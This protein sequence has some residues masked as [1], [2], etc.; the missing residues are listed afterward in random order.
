MTIRNSILRARTSRPRAPRRFVTRTL[1]GLALTALVIVVGNNWQV[2]AQTN[3]FVVEFGGD[4]TG[5]NDCTSPDQPCATI[6][7]AISQSGSGDLIVLGPGTYFE[8][9]TVSTGVIIQGDGTVGSTVNGNDAGSVFIVNNG[10]TASL[11]N[12][13]ITKDRKSTRLNSSHLKLSRMPSS[14]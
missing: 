12:L 9:V 2:R 8:N 11:N 3:R 14:A 10:I 1:T 6:Q 5:G 13:T 7:Y 4:D